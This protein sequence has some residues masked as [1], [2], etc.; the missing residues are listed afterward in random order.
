MKIITNITKKIL[1]N[2]KILETYQAGII[3][4]SCDI[5]QIKKDGFNITGNYIG[6]KNNELFLINENKNNIKLKILLKKKEINNLISLIKSKNYTIIPSKVYWKS[7]FIKIE[8]NL[9]IGKKKYDK[10][11]KEK[12]KDIEKFNIIN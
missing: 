1:F 7:K 10:R 9:C 2:Y 6:Y 12:I 8:I 5:K 11:V 4:N 3:L